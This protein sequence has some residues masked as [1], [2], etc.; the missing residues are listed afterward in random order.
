MPPAAP[1]TVVA[2]PA[3]PAPSAQPPGAAP[4]TPPVRSAGSAAAI[5]R[6][7]TAT[8]RLDTRR[9]NFRIWYNPANWNPA[10]ETDEGRVEFRQSSGQAVVVVIPEGTPL[11]LVA[12]RT[13]ALEN[14]RRSAPDA[15]IVAEQTRKIG[16]RDVLLL[17]IDATLTAGNQAVTY[18]GHYFGDP[19]GSIQV[20]GAVG[21]RDLERLRPVIQELL[22]GLD[23]NRP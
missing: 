15:R 22:D 20:V 16:S 14:A 18:L 2:Q 10:P 4:P 9:G 1:Q 23:L 19:R 17:Q 21:Q 11:P 3:L 8:A 5:Q 12:L 7:R 6:P 13:A